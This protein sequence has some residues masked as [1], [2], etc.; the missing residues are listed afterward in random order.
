MYL[1]KYNT[2]HPRT[3]LLVK[4]ILAGLFI[5]GG[6]VI[7]TLLL[8]PL[9]IDFV[10]VKQYGIWLTLSSIIGWASLFDVGLGHG[11]RNKFAEAIALNELERAKHYVS[12]AYF[13]LAIIIILLSL[14]YKILEPFINWAVILAAPQDTAYN[15][16]IVASI[17]V[18]TFLFQLLL[19][20]INSL[21]MASQLNAIASF[22]S[23]ISNLFS[24]VFIFIAKK[25]LTGNLVILSFIYS[26]V[27]TIVLL[28]Y[29]IYFF[30][31][32]YKKFKP[33]FSYVRI[34]DIKSLFGLG[35]LFF[36]IQI[37]VII[38]FQTANILIAHWFSAE[39]VAVYNI[40]YKYFSIISMSFSLIIAP[41][42]SA[43]TEA[44]SKNEITWI[45]K[46]I[47]KTIK[48]WLL[49]S[50]VGFILLILS[51]IGFRIWIGSRIEIPYCLSFLML[52]YVLLL[53]FGSIFVMFINGIGKIN[54]QTISS[55][56]SPLI[57]II[58]AYL[59]IKILSFGL[60]GIVLAIII[61]N[62]YGPII[63]PIQYLKF[64]KR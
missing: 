10:D 37:A 27:P 1:H 29:N 11:L 58:L 21:L 61:S 39:D 46:V 38:Q 47:N 63:A 40:C 54:V 28:F 7:C 42:W 30:N 59:F 45:K 52:I 51:P 20:L 5:K 33:K 53:C 3:K 49:F 56:I 14:I 34:S 55:L 57:F 9:T 6:V 64:I 48:L 12:S 13:T 18:Y 32:I 41:Y 19:K 23:L 35:S 24:L 4:N 26:I 8:V 60:S 43:F 44:Y 25:T 22:I 17:V 62:F 50:F 15:L 31:T 2:S 16:S 36:I